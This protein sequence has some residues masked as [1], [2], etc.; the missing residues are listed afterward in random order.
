MFYD[1][2]RFA[3]SGPQPLPSAPARAVLRPDFFNRETDGN[4]SF[5][6]GLL[7][8]L[9]PTCGLAANLTVPVEH[10]VHRLRL[11]NHLGLAINL[12]IIRAVELFS[13]HQQGHLR[14]TS[15]VF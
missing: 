9:V 7:A 8:D 10:D 15:D 4:T 3:C 1:A 11:R 6:E 12:Y 14:I 5:S 13:I 2:T